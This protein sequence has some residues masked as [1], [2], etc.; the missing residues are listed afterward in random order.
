M[1][2]RRAFTI[3]ELLVVIAIIGVLAALLMPAIQM[4]REAAR[5]TQCINNLDQCATGMISYDGKHQYLPPSRSMG[6]DKF[7]NAR[8]FNWVYPILPYLD[9]NQLYNE[10]RAAGLSDEDVGIETLVCPSAINLSSK[11]P[12]SYVVN[13]GRANVNDAGNDKYNFDWIENGVLIDKGIAL[14]ATGDPSYA[15][16]NRLLQSR[17]TLSTVAKYDG[18]SMTIL[19]SENNNVQDWRLAPAE[20]FGQ[21][22]WFD[23]ATVTPVRANENKKVDVATF[24]SNILYARPSSWHPGGYIAAFCDG[25]VRFL[26]EDLDYRVYGVLMSSRGNRANDPAGPALGSF[27]NAI[28]Q[29]QSRIRWVGST[30]T[31]NDAATYPADFYPEVD[32]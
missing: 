3:V 12:L 6:R 16:I 9:S 31:H 13:G 24:Q 14:P 5:R 1:S 27:G 18:Q 8:I 23:D 26:S 7:G 15:A 11:S 29:W 32:I 28:P 22:L 17:H 25:N 10:I 21:I 20:Q 2:S 4:A 19:L 30:Q